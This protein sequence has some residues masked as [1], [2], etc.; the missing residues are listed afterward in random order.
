MAC[1]ITGDNHRWPD[2]KIPYAISSDLSLD[3]HNIILRAIKIWNDSTVISLE[4]L[5]EEQDYVF[6]VQGPDCNSPVGKQG[7]RQEITC[8]FGQESS[9][10]HEIGHAVGL[11]H[12]Q[13]RTDRD[14]FIVVHQENVCPGEAHNFEKHVDDGLLIGPY[15][16]ASIMHY[17]SR[18]RA[19][20]WRPGSVIASQRCQ[21][22]PAIAVYHDRLHMVHLGESSNDLWWS[23]FDGQIWRGATG[24]PG[25]TRIPGQKSKFTPALAVF[26]DRLHMVHL[27]NSSND[28]WWSIFDGAKWRKPDGTE[29]NERIPGQKSQST[30]AL[31]V[32]NDRLHMVH[33]GD[34]SKDI[35][36]SIYDGVS[37]KKSN[38]S[39][40]NE[41]IPDQKSQASPALAV[42]EDRLHMVHLGN[43]S[44]DI[45]WSMYDGVSWKKADGTD[46]NERIPDQKSKVSPAL[47]VFNAQMHMA[48]LGDSSTDIWHSKYQNG[49]WS[50]NSR[51]YNGKSKASPVMAPLLRNVYMLH[52]GESSSRI[53]HTLHD[54]SQLVLVPPAGIDIGL[55]NLS[56]EDIRAVG[57]VYL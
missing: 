36:W 27:G 3:K 23:N 39:D 41:R 43:S 30:P 8:S 24:R 34:S 21:E 56:A 47:A 19:V 18:G 37:W 16:Y 11:W 12:E 13:S 10:V 51:T 38:G 9:I 29:G 20:D 35:W 32:F 22:G 31:A 57:E 6:F 15:D 17:S 33:L 14:L 52:A 2:R 25:N 26:N 28:I 48:H 1:F 42:F 44:N 45:W 40:G 55:D 50:A 54:T 4:P 5:S 7:N 53:Y 49:E 46:G